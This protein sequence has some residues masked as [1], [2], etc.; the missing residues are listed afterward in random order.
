[1]VCINDGEY[2]ENFDKVKKE[3]QEAL[4]KR[5]GEKSKFEK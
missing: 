5:L 4:D 2:V 3:L 1:M